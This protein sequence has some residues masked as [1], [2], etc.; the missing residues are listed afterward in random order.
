MKDIVPAPVPARTRAERLVRLNTLLDEAYADL[1]RLHSRPEKAST[2]VE[3]ATLPS[4]EPV[5]QRA[6]L[7]HRQ[8][9]WLAKHL[10]P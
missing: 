9:R 6:R 7:L 1:H 8:A 10:V 2:L 4:I 5:M 3:T